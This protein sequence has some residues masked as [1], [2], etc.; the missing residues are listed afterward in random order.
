MDGTRF[1]LWV[2]IPALLRRGSAPEGGGGLDFESLGEC[3][4]ELKRGPVGTGPGGSVPRKT[5]LV[6]VWSTTDQIPTVT[7]VQ[8]I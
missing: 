7:E 4:W 2:S 1:E 3:D 5:P 6:V 8:M